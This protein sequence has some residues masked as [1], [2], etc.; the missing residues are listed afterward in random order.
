MMKVWVVLDDCYD[1]NII[2]VTTD[3]KIADKAFDG[4]NAEL[5]AEGF[6]PNS[7]TERMCLIEQH[8]VVE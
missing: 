7:E 3:R 1:R 6:R 5:I 8:E 2:C 4:H